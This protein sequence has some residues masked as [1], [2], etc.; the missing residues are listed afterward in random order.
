MRVNSAPGVTETANG[1]LTVVEGQGARL[2]SVNIAGAGAEAD[3]GVGVG[4]GVGVGAD[5]GGAA[6]VAAAMPARKGAA[7]HQDLVME[8]V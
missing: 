8:T 5:T 6:A 1:T 3:T 4:V 7:A 2:E